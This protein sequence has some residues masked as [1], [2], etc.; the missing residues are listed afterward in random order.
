M[1]RFINGEA[2]VLLSTT[3]IES[4]LDIPIIEAPNKKLFPQPGH[5]IVPRVQK[6][7]CIQIGPLR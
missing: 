3:I 4:G 7:Q 1:T 2:D 5:G 6:P